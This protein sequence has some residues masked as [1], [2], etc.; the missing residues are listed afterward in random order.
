MYCVRLKLHQRSMDCIGML[1]LTYDNKSNNKS[2]NI[3][4]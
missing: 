4:A 1:K 3:E 2:I